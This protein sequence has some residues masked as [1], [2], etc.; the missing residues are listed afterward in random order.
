M[1]TEL[2]FCED[3]AIGWFLSSQGPEQCAAAVGSVLFAGI[4]SQQA[5][6][7]CGNAPTMSTKTKRT[8]KMRVNGVAVV[9]RDIEFTAF[10]ID[11]ARLERR[12]TTHRSV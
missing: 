9:M 6:A 8:P 12:D 3:V 2:T 11:L 4:A 5:I 1:E 7:Q 10:M